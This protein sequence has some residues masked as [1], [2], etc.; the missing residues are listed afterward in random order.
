MEQCKWDIEGYAWGLS[1]WRKERAEW[2]C[3]SKEI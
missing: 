2:V 1:I 3:S